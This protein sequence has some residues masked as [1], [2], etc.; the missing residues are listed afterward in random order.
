MKS[1]RARVVSKEGSDHIEFAIDL[2][3]EILDGC[4]CL[5]PAKPMVLLGRSRAEHAEAIP[6]FYSHSF[7][8]FVLQGVLTSIEVHQLKLASIRANA[9]VLMS[10]NSKQKSN[11]NNFTFGCS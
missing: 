10:T 5:R 8:S 1:K 6:A 4:R 9:K 3:I 7:V 11:E 2:D